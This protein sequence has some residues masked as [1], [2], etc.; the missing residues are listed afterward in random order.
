MAQSDASRVKRI[1]VTGAGIMGA[2]I[3]SVALTKGIEVELYDVKDTFLDR[4]VS[5]V[6]KHLSR[7]VDKGTLNKDSMQVALSLFH[8]TLSYD[9]AAGVD[10]AIEAA[11][12]SLPLKREIFRKL[13]EVVGDNALLA[14]NTSSLSITAISAVVRD[15]G[16]VA[17]IH[18]FNP[19]PSMELVEL[20]S[21]YHT[22]KE[23]YERAKA[24]AQSLG[25]TVTSSRDSPGFVT[26]RSVGVLI[27]EAVFMLQEG[28]ASRE[29]I[30]TAH[31][32]GFHHPMGPLELADLVGLDTALAIL[33]RLQTGFGDPKYRAAPLL[34]QMVEAGRL[35]RKSGEGFYSYKK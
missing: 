4:G 23:T 30:D 7:M 33:E 12:E 1:F 15:P 32:L 31:K 2:G 17:G 24:F 9:E 25:K 18:F 19:V 6:N 27:N 11:P 21:G 13:D 5:T 14:S 35:G 29:D 22:R 3:A 10:V 26:T 16:R 20:I 8:P 34:V 28:V